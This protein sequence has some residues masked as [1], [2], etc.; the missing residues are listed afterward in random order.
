MKKIILASYSFFLFS[1]SATLSMQTC[2]YNILQSKETI[3][4][5]ARHSLALT[6]TLCRVNKY[7][8]KLLC[9]QLPT[10]N[11]RQSTKHPKILLNLEHLC[12]LIERFKKLNILKISPENITHSTPINSVAIQTFLS[13]IKTPKRTNFFIILGLAHTTATNITSVLDFWKD[14]FLKNISPK[15]AKFKLTIKGFD[16]NHQLYSSFMYHRFFKDHSQKKIRLVAK[17]ENPFN[18][19]F[20]NLILDTFRGVEQ[21]TLVLENFFFSPLEKHSLELVDFSQLKHYPK[22]IIL[23]CL[24]TDSPAIRILHALFTRIGIPVQLQNLDPALREVT[25]ILGETPVNL[26]RDLEDLSEE[27]RLIA[28]MNQ[29]CTGIPIQFTSMRKD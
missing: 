9:E 28:Q 8:K 2:N 12:A 21:L 26:E 15:D 22:T 27:Q 5:I 3:L 1:F 4:E 6:Y 25:R 17:K 16:R 7:L 13:K 14:C 10:V 24:N 19:E 20:I 18:L 23:D 29:N 11:L